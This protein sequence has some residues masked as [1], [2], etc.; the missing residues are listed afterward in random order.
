[1]KTL[2]VTLEPDGTESWLL[3]RTPL[4]NEPS[5]YTI[6]KDLKYNQKG[7]EGHIIYIDYPPIASIVTLH[8][9]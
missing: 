2:Y 7:W 1:M 9:L 8:F 3:R 4:P 6:I 5:R